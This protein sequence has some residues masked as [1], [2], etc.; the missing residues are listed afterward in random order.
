MI[1]GRQVLFIIIDWYRVTAAD[2]ARHDFNFLQNVSKK[3][4]NLDV[5]LHEW[6]TALS[7]LG[8][9]PAENIL[10]SLF[11]KRVQHHP[12]L[13]PDIAYYDRLP[14]GHS[15]RTYPW[16]YDRVESYLE[17]VRIQHARNELD[18]G[19]KA[20]PIQSDS[21]AVAERL[22]QSILVHRQMSTRPLPLAS[23]GKSSLGRGEQS[24]AQR[25]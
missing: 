19:R 14:Q 6:D 18:G 1:T 5:F 9:T 25:Q 4:G 21:D 23:Q 13:R 22:L 12:E 15:E 24:P 2:G 3:N 20:L 11:Y 8:E 16:L 10:E 7:R 17:R